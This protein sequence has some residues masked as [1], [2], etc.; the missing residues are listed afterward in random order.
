MNGLFWILIDVKL[1]ENAQ[2]GVFTNLGFLGPLRNSLIPRCAEQRVCV[3]RYDTLDICVVTLEDLAQ[4]VAHVVWV[5][6]VM[7]EF[8]LDW[9]DAKVD[10]KWTDGRT[11]YDE[12]ILVNR[13]P[14]T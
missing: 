13:Y 5:D 10:G 9:L 4:R 3:D 11:K 1:H 6:D 14:E 12:T 8:H 2:K 7:A